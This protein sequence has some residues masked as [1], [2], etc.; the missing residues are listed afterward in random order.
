ML[1]DEIA[2]LFDGRSFDITQLESTVQSQ[3]IQ[4]NNIIVIIIIIVRTIDN[5]SVWPATWLI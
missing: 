4:Y 5:N 3:Y 2:S 1:T